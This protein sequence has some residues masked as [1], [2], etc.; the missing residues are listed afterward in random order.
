ME[1]TASGVGEIPGCTWRH[2]LCLVSYTIT[3]EMIQCHVI[4][5]LVWCSHD[6]QNTHWDSPR[7]RRQQQQLR[8]V[9]SF[10]QEHKGKL[11]V[12]G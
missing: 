8:E 10:I 6:T 9:R 1:Q 11:K 3:L 7:G 4:A 5:V 2:L 12:R